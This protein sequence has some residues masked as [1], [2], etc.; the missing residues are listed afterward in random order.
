MTSANPQRQA[1]EA[2]IGPKG[3]TN[4]RLSTPAE[5]LEWKRIGEQELGYSHVES[6]PLVRS[7]YKADEQAV[8]FDLLARRSLPARHPTQM[9]RAR[10]GPGPP[11]RER[12]SC[13]RPD[14]P[15]SAHLSTWRSRGGRARLP[16]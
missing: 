10:A 5:F 8:K 6:G 12:R 14:C 11:A 1:A 15:S 3:I 16:A 13:H 7:S 2:L 4:P 9:A